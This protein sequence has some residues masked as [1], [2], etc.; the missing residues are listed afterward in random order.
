[1]RFNVSVVALVDCNNFYA[2]CE[3]VFNPKLEGKPVVVLSNNDGIVVAASNEA[4]A[5]GLTL[6]VPIF[7]AEGLVKSGQV[8]VFSSNYTLYGDM[9]K[10]VMETLSRFTPE[11][12]IY[13]IDEAFLNLSGI[14][15]SNLTIYS[16]RIRNTVIQWTGIPVSI[17]IAETK[18]LAKIANR[19]AKR[20]ERTNGVLNLTASPY[21]KKAL[22]I[23]S[24]EN[25]WGIGRSY[26]KFLRKHRIETAL[27]LRNAE[28]SWIRKHMSIVGLRIVRELRGIPCI[29]MELCHPAK[30]EICVSKSFGKSVET[31]TEI[32]EAVAV[33]VS[34]AAEKLRNQN[35]AAG[36]IMVFMMTNR[37]KDEP[38]YV[39]YTVLQL[40]VHTNNTAELIQHALRGVDSIY[41]K[42]YKFKK[43]GVVLREIRPANQI[44]TNLFDNIDRTKATKVVEVFDTINN[45]L[46]A[47][48]IKYAAEGLVNPW[49]TMFNKRSPKYT[50]RWDE[51]PIVS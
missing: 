39:N 27:D 23:T 48:T 51:L 6:G 33:Y 4:K 30:K 47:G 3:R 50:T 1:M 5:L 36:S 26:A 21:Q 17:G 37:F 20:S 19:I 7:Q 41:Q 12:E 42:G 24:V 38:Q 49:K 35:S 25:I 15:R 13:S 2:S 16:H 18:V 11:L 8:H 43:A 9:S 34:R 29:S 40:P 22:A 32:R 14:T 45:Q 44:Q 46:G 31:I 28:D 10:R